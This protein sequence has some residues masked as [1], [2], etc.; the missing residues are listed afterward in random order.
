MVTRTLAESVAIPLHVRRISA[1]MPSVLTEVLRG[2][3]KSLHSK[4]TSIF[5]VSYSLI[6]LHSTLTVDKTK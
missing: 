5:P 2:F 3:L 4:T 6:I 1:A